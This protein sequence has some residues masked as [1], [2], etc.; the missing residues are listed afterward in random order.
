MDIN[1]IKELGLDALSAEEQKK[2]I[3]NIGRVIRQ[4]IILRVMELLS[5]EEKDEFDNLL[6]EKADDEETIYKFLK[7]KISNLDEIA[8][9]E[10]KNFKESSLDLMRD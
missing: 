7:S 8:E 10:I 9:E 1:L 5:E 6:S 3:L 2:A 4:N